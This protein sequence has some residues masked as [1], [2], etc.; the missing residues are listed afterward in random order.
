MRTSGGSSARAIS[1]QRL[2][3]LADR[4]AGRER[5][6][7]GDGAQPVEA[8]E[9]LR[10]RALLQAD[11]GRERHE[12]AAGGAHEHVRE[13][14]RR[15][16]VLGAGAHDDVVFLA[17][18]G[19]ARDLLLAEHELERLADILDRD[20][21]VGGA[22]AV[23][24]DAQVGLVLL[25]VG[26]EVDEEPGRLRLRQ[27]AVAPVAQRLVVG[28]ADHELDLLLQAALAERARV[29][30]EGAR[31]GEVRHLAEHLLDDVLLPDGALV[32][33]NQAQNEQPLVHRRRPDEAGRH[34]AQRA[35]D[36]SARAQR[37]DRAARP[38]SAARGC[39]RGSTPRAPGP[40]SG[41]SRGPRSARTPSGSPGTG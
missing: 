35:R 36:Q 5:A 32:P 10:R 19:E 34:D 13:V 38:P 21:E 37:L 8:V 27:H 24:L 33:G 31:A 28:A 3:A 41:R 14:V 29:D 30:R 2:E 15:R 11:E 16:P 17:L 26:I 25:V 20:A 39:N 9:L 4:H 23:D 18:R 22:G 1:L 6:L 40:G 12:V 7:D